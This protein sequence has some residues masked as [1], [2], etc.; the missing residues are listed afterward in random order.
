MIME[1]TFNNIEEM[2]E[3]VLVEEMNEETL[4][5]VDGGSVTLSVGVVCTVIGGAYAAGWAIGLGIAN[6]VKR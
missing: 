3:E 4:E 6:I 5:N 2:N 1:K